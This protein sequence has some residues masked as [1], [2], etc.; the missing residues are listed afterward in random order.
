MCTLFRVSVDV[1]LRP[2]TRF[3]RADARVTHGRTTGVLRK[4]RQPFLTAT[5]TVP[6]QG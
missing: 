1:R 3:P 2:T 4:W 6:D 5:D